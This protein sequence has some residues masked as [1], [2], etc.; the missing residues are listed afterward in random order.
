[1]RPRHRQVPDGRDRAA[2]LIRRANGAGQRKN[3][4]AA[5]LLLLLLLLLRLLPAPSPLLR[6]DCWRGR[7]AVRRGA[8]VATTARASSLGTGTVVAAGAAC[9]TGI[10]S[11]VVATTG[12]APNGAISRRGQVKSSLRPAGAGTASPFCSTRVATG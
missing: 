7:G 12:S 3:R 5:P 11:V 4:V 1:M 10:G 2:A 8:V 9:M 6:L